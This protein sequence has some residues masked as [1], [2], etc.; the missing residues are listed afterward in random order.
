MEW[1][2]ETQEKPFKDFIRAAFKHAV[3]DSQ[4][5]YIVLKGREA[6]FYWEL[7]DETVDAFGWG[8]R[9]ATPW[10]D[11]GEPDE[12]YGW[13]CVCCAG[14]DELRQLFRNAGL[15]C[16][17]ILKWNSEIAAQVQDYNG[18]VVDY[19]GP[20]VN[21]LSTDFDI[22]LIAIDGQ[23]EWDRFADEMSQLHLLTRFR[24]SD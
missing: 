18:F 13:Y 6:D 19:D 16:V 10:M 11:G 4:Y 24:I 15:E 21:P 8:I 7:P 23:P 14:G 17:F 3:A 1:I 2:S 12:Q 9:F 22:E 5:P 20:V